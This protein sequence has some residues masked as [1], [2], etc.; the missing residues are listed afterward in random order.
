MELHTRYHEPL[1][2]L[3]PTAA[4]AA[5]QQGVRKLLFMADPERVDTQLKPHW[6][7]RRV[8][9]RWS[10]GSGLWEGGHF[11]AGVTGDHTPTLAVQHPLQTP[12]RPP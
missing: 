3:V 10:P 6:E 12:L 1:P 4:A 9:R 8:W 2:F 11:L 7:V 5:G